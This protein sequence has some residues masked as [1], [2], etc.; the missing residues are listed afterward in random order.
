MA[1]KVLLVED[2][3]SIGGL[4]EAAF[5]GSGA[6]VTWF[7]YGKTALENFRKGMYDICIL[8]FSLP[9]MDGFA[10]SSQIKSMEN[11]PFLFVTANHETQIKYQAFEKGCDD[12]ILKPFKIR[13]LVLRVE[14]ILRRFKQNNQQASGN[15]FLPNNF[16]FD[17]NSRTISFESKLT[18]LSAKESLILKLL[19][20]NINQ[21]VKR[22]A[23][24]QEVWGTTDTYTSKCLDVYLSK[25]R[26]L[27]KDNTPL[28]IINEHGIGYKIIE[29]KSV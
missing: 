28:E 26:K 9:D 24:M 16:K 29:L 14:A 7:T 23:I 20:D 10:L 1:Y 4:I 21:V 3:Q 27:I 2:D 13:E 19:L 15:L 5:N 8:D 22:K 6:Q 12:F 17:H 18:K 25:L 11:V